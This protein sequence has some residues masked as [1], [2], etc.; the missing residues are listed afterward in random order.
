MLGRMFQKRGQS[1]Y[2]GPKGPN[3]LYVWKIQDH[4]MSRVSQGEGY[5]ARWNQRKSQN[6]DHKRLP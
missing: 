6:L 2:K 1:E 5:G 4:R 3:A